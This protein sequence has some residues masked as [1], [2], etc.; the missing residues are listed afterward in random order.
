MRRLICV[1]SFPVSLLLS[2]VFSAP[3]LAGTEQL[4]ISSQIQ[5]SRVIQGAQDP[6][7]AFIY[8]NAP[9]GSDTASYKVFATFPYGNSTSYVGTKV[10]DGGVNSVPLLFTFDSSKVAPGNN[11]PVS[12][13]GIN[14]ANNASLTQ[15]GTVTVLA[16]S[17]PAL[18]YQGQI[19]YLTSK[20]QLAPTTDAFSQV[21][22]SGTELQGGF[23]AAMLGD[24]PGVPTAMLDLD[25]VTATG[26]PYITTTLHPFFDLP[27][28]D[29]PAEAL[30]F[31]IDIRAPG[32][33]DYLT[34]FTLHY[35]DEDDLPGAAPPGSEAIS[36]SVECNL[37]PTKAFWK[38]TSVP[39]P[40]A[41][42]LALT[43]IG[44]FAAPVR[45]GHSSRPN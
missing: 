43:A 44:G 6:V 34:V 5:Y 27:S 10:A 1:A 45:R 37:T 20:S 18:Y 23:N 4:A 39:E 19:V 7:T 14:T 15:S 29:D 35:S 9:P 28:D 17:T 16:H 30:P 38:L 25:S 12:V 26:S 32:P 36:F 21:A 2:A 31:E 40:S 3:S 33:G 22:P 8:N 42:L 24:P 41:M 13:T 11:I